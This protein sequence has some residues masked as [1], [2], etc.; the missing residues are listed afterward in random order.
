M[1]AIQPKQAIAGDKRYKLA[2]DFGIYL[3]VETQCPK[4]WRV[5]YRFGGK[6]KTLALGAYPE[7]SL[8]EARKARDKARKQL[9]SDVDPCLERK[10]SKLTASHRAQNSFEA[11]ASEWRRG[12]SPTWTEHA[13]YKNLRILQINA[14]PWIGERAIGEVTAPELLSFSGA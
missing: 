1:T 10:V 8:A 4:Y 2:D 14:F 13:R 3:L 9:R 6:R 5:D 11:I 12:F 7:V